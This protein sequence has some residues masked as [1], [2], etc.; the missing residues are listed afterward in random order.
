MQTTVADILR[1]KG[2]NVLTT[3]PTTTVFDAISKMVDMNVGSILVTEGDE[4]LGIF[5]ERDYLR[6]IILQGRA[7]KTTRIEE[8]MTRD[9]LA[10]DPQFTI[11][12]CMATM[13][14]RKCR[15]LPVMEDGHLI[16]VISLGDCAKEKAGEAEARVRYLTD[17]IT[18]KYPV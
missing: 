10:A 2:R 14:S 13:T 17:Y 18:G 15:H 11:D 5:T 4:V 16:G 6:R 3:E 1:H 12:D 9:V 8:V 7:S